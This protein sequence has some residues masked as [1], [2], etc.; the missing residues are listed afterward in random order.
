MTTLRMKSEEENDDSTES[1]DDFLRRS[2]KM[3][4]S[5]SASRL[6]KRK[7]KKFV[8]KH[9]TTSKTLVACLEMKESQRLLFYRELMLS[10]LSL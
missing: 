9:K 5:T 10:N 3:W 4:K 7:R 2:K 6:H 8:L 1:L